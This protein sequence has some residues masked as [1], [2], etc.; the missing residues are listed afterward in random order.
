MRFKYQ[1]PKKV[2][3]E[4]SSKCQLKCPLCPTGTKKNKNGIN[5]RRK[6]KIS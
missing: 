3:I 5:W 1:L 4:A 6:F 2:L